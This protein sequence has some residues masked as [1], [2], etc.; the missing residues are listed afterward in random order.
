MKNTLLILICYNHTMKKLYIRFLASVTPQS[1]DQLMKII[2]MGI[3]ES[4]EELHLMI[5]TPG[6]SVL[7]GIS[8]YN[9]LMSIP[10]KRY[11][12]N[13]G[14]VDSI[15]VIIYC[16]GEKRY[17]MPHGRFLI[18]PVQFNMQSNMPY[19][20]KKLSEILSGI[21]MDQ[22]NIIKIIADTIAKPHEQ[23]HQS[24]LDRLTLNPQDALTYGLAHSIRAAEISQGTTVYSVGDFVQGGYTQSV[25]TG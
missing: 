15:G 5:S 2:D 8:L 4:Y 11:T 19:D 22:Y 23:I 13:F 16:A 10:I 14:S 21:E 17:C 6:G 18:H 3:K 7:Y 24:M 12:Y 20:E 25:Q 1:T 9:F